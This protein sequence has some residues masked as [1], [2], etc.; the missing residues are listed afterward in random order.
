MIPLVTILAC[1]DSAKENNNSSS[2]IKEE[3]TYFVENKELINKEQYNVT[4]YD[5][6]SSL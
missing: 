3:S 1:F 2:I 6:I 5:K 4:Y